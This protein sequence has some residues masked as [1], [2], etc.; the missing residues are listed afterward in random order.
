MGSSPGVKAVTA[1]LSYDVGARGLAE[2]AQLREGKA[3]AQGHTA[4]KWQ[5]PSVRTPRSEPFL[6]VLCCCADP[7]TTGRTGSPVTWVSTAPKPVPY[8]LH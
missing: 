7:Q 2:A 4:E 3:L 8:L 6:L 5:S 1:A